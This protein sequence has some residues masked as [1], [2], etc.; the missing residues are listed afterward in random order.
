MVPEMITK[1]AMKKQKREKF[2]QIDLRPINTERLKPL[3]LETDKGY[4][5]IRED[6]WI[7]IYLSK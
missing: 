6:S 3:K 5:K 1:S 7:V 4:I 2:M